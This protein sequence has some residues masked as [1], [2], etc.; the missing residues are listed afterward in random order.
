MI[1]GLAGSKPYTKSFYDLKVFFESPEVDEFLRNLATCGLGPE[2]AHSGETIV[3]AA[4]CLVWI[5]LSFSVPERFFLLTHI[6][7]T[8][9]FTLIG[10]LAV[11]SYLDFI[12][13]SIYYNP[14]EVF[15]DEW[16]GMFI[17]LTLIKPKQ[18]VAPFLAFLLFRFFSVLS[19][20]PT[21][22]AD[23]FYGATRVILHDITAGAMAAVL[24]LFL[25]ILMKPN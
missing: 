10:Y 4:A 22:W 17:A 1:L 11:Q 25:N 23:T 24:S 8:I 19:I 13:A 9:L 2:L 18:F 14:Q 6:C 7:I 12:D 16:A 5:G 3:P 21:L 20:G 15:I